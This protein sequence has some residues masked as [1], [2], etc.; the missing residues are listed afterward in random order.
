MYI[1]KYCTT[2]IIGYL[3]EHIDNKKNTIQQQDVLAFVPSSATL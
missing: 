1:I 2:E 3:D